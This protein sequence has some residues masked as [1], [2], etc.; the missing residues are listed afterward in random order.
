MI[1]YIFISGSILESKYMK[2]IFIA[3]IGALLKEYNLKINIKKITYH[4]LART[5]V[6]YSGH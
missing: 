2:A 6:T 4:K 3:S 5:F 1:K